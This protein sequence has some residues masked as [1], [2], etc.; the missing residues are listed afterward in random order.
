MYI[1]EGDHSTVFI[2]VTS[3]HSKWYDLCLALG[4]PPSL[5]SRIKREQHDTEACLRE[6]LVAWLRRSYIIEK[7]GLPT[8]RKLVEAIDHPEGGSDH[9]LALKITEEHK[10]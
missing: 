5:L 2:S 8:G 3:L 7:H 10:S 1:D 9:T 6:G 4:L